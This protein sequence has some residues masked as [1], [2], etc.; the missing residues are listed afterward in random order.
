[1]SKQGPG[2]LNAGAD[3]YRCEACARTS[4]KKR[5]AQ[6]AWGVPVAWSEA[7]PS[8]SALQTPSAEL[9]IHKYT[10]ARANTDADTDTQIHKYRY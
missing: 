4:R 9:Q 2:I 6:L 7:P 8:A 10:C 1:M 3:A 5:L